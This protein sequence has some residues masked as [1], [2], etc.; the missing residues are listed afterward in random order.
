VPTRTTAAVIL[1]TIGVALSSC[2]LALAGGVT[3]SAFLRYV[4]LVLQVVGFGTVALGLADIRERF[5]D[6]P[7]LATRVGRRLARGWAGAEMRVRRLL[8]RPVPSTALSVHA[9]D[10]ATA[11]DSVTVEVGYGQLNQERPVAE[12]IA[13]LDA[14]TRDIRQRVNR[15]QRDLRTEAGARES[16]V[17][18]ERRAR[19]AADAGLDRELA[20][21]AAG[22]LRLEWWGVWMFLAGT[23]LS[24]VPDE[25]ARL[26]V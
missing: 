19:D 17:T 14:R 8:R 15:L 24:T 16:A 2:S 3:L 23:V 6:R 26:L 11:A 25:L 22:G 18:S 5:T 13:E 12:L 21:L 7:S 20:D 9:A 4:G 10:S 1:S